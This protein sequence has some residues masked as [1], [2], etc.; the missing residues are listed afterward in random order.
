MPSNFAASS[1]YIIYLV[2][3]Y[4]PWAGKVPH[5]Q[6]T[7]E[8]LGWLSSLDS[9]LN[10]SSTQSVENIYLFR[11]HQTSF[12]DYKSDALDDVILA[13]AL[14]GGD[15]FHATKWGAHYLKALYIHATRSALKR[16]ISIGQGKKA[17]QNYMGCNPERMWRKTFFQDTPEGF[18]LLSTLNSS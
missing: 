15:S 1:L 16:E 3:D 10:C 5:F 4:F 18:S 9:G 7:S 11:L 6:E 14:D 8:V 2:T 17:L 13:I 12:P